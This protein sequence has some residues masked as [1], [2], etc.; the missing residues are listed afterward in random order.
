MA[1]HINDDT[2]VGS[3]EAT[4]STQCGIIVYRDGENQ[5]S[6]HGLRVPVRGNERIKGSRY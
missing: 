2:E 3:V 4:A 1:G 6:V 5:L